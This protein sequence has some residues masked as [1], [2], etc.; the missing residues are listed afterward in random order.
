MPT[1]KFDAAVFQGRKTV[2]VKMDHPGVCQLW[3]W[4]ER[5]KRYFS[6]TTGNRYYAYRKV[7]GIQRSTFCSSYEEAK[8]WRDSGYVGLTA[9][10]ASKM[11]FAEAKERFF[12]WQIG[13]V[14]PSTLETYRVNARHLG[15]FDKFL[16]RDIG[17][18]EVESWLVAMKRPEYLATQHSNRLSYEHDLQLL[19]QILSYYAEYLDDAY[20]VPVKKRHREDAVVNKERLLAVRDQRERKYMP[21]E[22]MD[23]FLDHLRQKA[24]KDENEW[25]FYL[26]ALIQLRTGGRPGEVASLRWQ[27]V[28]FK[29]RSV[30]ISR[31]VY[32]AKT[33][34]R[35]TSI[36]PT[37]KSGVSRLVPSVSEDVFTALEEWARK[38]GR[39]TGLICADDAFR[40]VEYR[41]IQHR[42]DKAFRELGMPYS[43]AHILRHSFATDFLLKTGDLNA[44]QGILGHSR[45]EQTQ[46]YAK[47]VDELKQAA[48]KTYGESLKKEGN[49]VKISAEAENS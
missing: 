15:F 13:R 19:R 30:F 34:E 8:K 48:M 14:K 21:A 44:L 18:R 31:T 5:K 22:E 16:V 49:V 24:E 3:D 28:S 6:R 10:N 40:P 11:T 35:E 46:V 12:E 45:I 20:K 29:N 47:I 17:P 2:T 33:K 25:P 42:F 39:R 37:T 36:S 27:D 4:D 38:S 7:N 23:R 32:W 41:W 1:K 43:G 26:Q 9:L